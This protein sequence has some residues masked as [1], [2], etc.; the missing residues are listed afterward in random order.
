MP[1]NRQIL[2]LFQPFSAG[3]ASMVL[4]RRGAISYY[5]MAWSLQTF[6]LVKTGATNDEWDHI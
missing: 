6:Q 4:K 3:L 5:P 2:P 1:C